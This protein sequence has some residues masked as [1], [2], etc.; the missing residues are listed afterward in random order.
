M[1]KMKLMKELKKLKKK[2]FKSA[3]LGKRNVCYI[4]YQE[5]PDGFHKF[6]SQFT[7]IDNVVGAVSFA[8][9]DTDEIINYLNKKYNKEK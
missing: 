7:S 9:S 5:M 3:Q 4:T 8:A 1:K 6:G 2:F